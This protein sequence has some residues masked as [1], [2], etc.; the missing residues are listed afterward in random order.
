MSKRFLFVS[1]AIALSCVSLFFLNSEQPDL[2]LP[3]SSEQF[4]PIPT[5]VHEKM[6]DE[7][8][9]ENAKEQYLELC[10]TNGLEIDWKAIIQQNFQDRVEWRKEIRQ[11]KAVVSYANGE[12]AGE[13]FERGSTNQA[14]NVRVSVYE[15]Q[16]EAVYAISDEGIL[17]KGDLLNSPWESLNDSYVLSPDV[18]ETV[19]MPD[20]S[21]R[22]LS[23]VGSRIY[24]S[25]DE[26]ETWTM[27]DGFNGGANG[28]GIDLFELSDD[29]STIVYLYTQ[30]NFLG[31]GVNK[32]AYSTDHGENFTEVVS[33]TSYNSS[34]ASMATLWNSSVA[35]VLNKNE[36][37]YKFEAGNFTQVSSGL[38]LSGSSTVQV[39]AVMD[40]ADTV[41]YVLTN[42][43]NLYKSTDAGN[44]FSTVG[45][46]ASP[47]WDCGIGVSIDDPNA[48][49]Y[50]EVDLYRS[51]DGGQNWNMV[52]SWGDYYS[53]PSFYI[54]ADIMDISSFKTAGGTEFTLICNHGGIN[55]SYD[56]CITT[57]NVGMTDLNVGQY[58]DIA[59]SPINS[60]FMIGGTQDQGLQRT[61]LAASTGK[62]GFEQVISGDY[63]AQQFS[64]NGQSFWT[65][66]PFGQFSYYPNATSGGA[67]YWY[68][69]DG[70]NMPN[71][72]WIIPTGA[73]PNPSD[74]YILVGG[75]SATGG[76]G[77]YLIKL[78]NVGGTAVATNFPFNF[79]DDAGQPI[80]AMETTP[81]D[82]NKWYVCTENGKFY[83][84]EDAGQNWTQSSNLN[85]PANNWI[86]TSDIY[87]SRLTAGLV[88]IGG[89]N[90]IQSSVWVSFDGGENFVQTGD[91]MPATMTHEM[92]MDSNEEFLF[93][94]TDAGPYVYS[95]SQEE[96]F[97]LGGLDAPIQSYVSCEFVENEN[98]ARFASYGRGIWDF[99][100][101]DVTSI[102]ENPDENLANIYP[103]PSSNGQFTFNYI[104]YSQVKVV[105]MQ[106]R[107]VVEFAILPGDNPINLSFLN[108]G[109]YLMVGV[110][111]HGR[112]IK[113]KVV[114]D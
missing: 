65:E 18:I 3:T 4:I 100:L 73:A 21:L 16:S 102:E 81:L 1:G 12:I 72:N 10:H 48:L 84:S 76:D 97:Y 111:A 27:A 82:E 71:A 96:W 87:A 6:E 58:Y 20:G 40:G 35:F 56:K 109:T 77:S 67:A 103:N 24:Y 83:H 5:Q 52:S 66:Y 59:T 37:I 32:F 13:W 53:D 34:T 110:D 69:I 95:M 68:D 101:S 17:F 108:Q 42:G 64:N 93:A 62:V 75:G 2:K 38:G 11:N 89:T 99:K 28:T 114:I 43:S 7:E 15:E 55:V 50:G 98:T 94:A 46:L 91:G 39:E 19:R 44:N 31:N 26:G 107:I 22:L 49:Y 74:D 60:A 47:A 14:G 23:T 80:A 57:P 45:P 113:E 70:N 51:T 36:E 104:D 90:Y 33:L 54:H 86:W 92:C 63:G 85:L 106:G 105:D 29:D 88:F 79:L 61:S 9:F 41:L 112:T 25:D 30:V 8:A 78:E